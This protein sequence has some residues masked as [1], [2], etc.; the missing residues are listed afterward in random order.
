MQGKYKENNCKVNTEDN[1]EFNS[2][3]TVICSFK[4]EPEDKVFP[5]E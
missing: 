4:K 5:Q 1:N 2:L 3:E